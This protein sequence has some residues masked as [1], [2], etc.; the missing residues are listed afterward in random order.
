[1]KKYTYFNSIHRPYYRSFPPKAALPPIPALL[2]VLFKPGLGTLV[3][4]GS[5]P[6][7]LAGP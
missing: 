5:L 3:G 7:P 1:M 6:P 2:F 4:I